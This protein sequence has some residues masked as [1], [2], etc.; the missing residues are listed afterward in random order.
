MTKESVKGDAV[1]LFAVIREAGPAWT[2]GVGAF[3]QPG[4]SGHAAFMNRLAGD[5]IVLFAGPLDGTEVGRIRVL[6]VASAPDRETVRH[7]MADDPWEASA[8]IRT[9]SVEPWSLFVGEQRLPVV[10]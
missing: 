8:Q 9:V 4:A 7:R 1:K 5:G 6:L 2:D 3:D 10:V